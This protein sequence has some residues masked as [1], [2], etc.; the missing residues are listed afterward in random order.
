MFLN[1]TV[2][3]ITLLFT[4]TVHKY[5]YP[6]VSKVHAGSFRVSVIHYTKL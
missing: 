5:M 2:Q 1:L 3:I 6:S 4:F